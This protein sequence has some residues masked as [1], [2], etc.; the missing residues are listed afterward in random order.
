MVEELDQ[1][2]VGVLKVKGPGAI[3]VGLDGMDQF[4]AMALDSSRHR[5]DIFGARNDESD[6]M[7]SL[8]GA[9]VLAFRK[10]VD[11]KIIGSRAQINVIGVGL[12]FDV[13]TSTE[14]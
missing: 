3:A 13:H 12:P 14:Q 4:D 6:V 10:L 9:G 8:H 5:I 2:S 11:C 7:N 1:K